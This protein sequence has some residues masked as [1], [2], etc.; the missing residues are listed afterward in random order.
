MK[1]IYSTALIISLL[2]ACDV[3]GGPKPADQPDAGDSTSWPIEDTLSYRSLATHPG[4]SQSSMTYAPASVADYTCAAKLY[5]FPTGT[6]EDTSAPI[7]VLVHGNSDTPAGFERFPLDGEMPG[8]DQLAERLPAAGLRTYAI[9]LRIDLV[10]DPQGNNDTENAA[11]NIDH[12]WAVPLLQTFYRS[13][14][15]ANPGRRISLIG[16]SLGSTVIRDALRRM[17]LE[18]AK[19][20]DRLEDVVLLA[21]ANHGVSSCALCGA[22]P[23]MRGEVTC[24]MGCRDNFSPTPFLEALNGP[25][26]AYETPC[27]D[28]DRAFGETGACGDN[29]VA[30]TTIVMRDIDNGTYQDLFVSEASARLAGA[31]N[32]LIALEDVDESGYFFDGLFKNH[33]GSARSEAAL[34]I[35]LEKVTD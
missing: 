27:A 1:P 25:G 35:I 33:Y 24:Q 2:A 17:H 19:P 26:G 34:E 12:G 32:R 13:L 7:V 14:L 22:N 9:D 8:I 31:D 15:A 6:S 21:G 28:G 29:A 16:F 30:Y 5:P 18:G 20:F 4:C 10:D 23:T 3:T 11:R